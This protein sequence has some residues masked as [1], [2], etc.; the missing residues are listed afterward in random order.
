MIKS[1]FKKFI[2]SLIMLAVSVS[3]FI[4]S[5]GFSFNPRV[6]SRVII[7]G[8]EVGGLTY[9]EAKNKV[10][11]GIE[12][13]L[14]SKSLSVVGGSQTYTFRY[15]EIGYKDN[16]TE[17]MKDA[18]KGGKYR[19]QVSYYLC[20]LNTVASAICFNESV[21]VV[22]PYADFSRFGKPFTYHEG[23]DGKNVDVKQLKADICSS[24]NGDFGRVKLSFTKSYRTQTLD[25]VKSK[26]K[27]LASFTTYFDS[28]NLSRTSNIR[29]ASSF[30]NGAV[31]PAGKTIS[32]NDTV[33][34]RKKSRGFL[35]AKIIE[36]G[37]FTDGV[38]GGVCQ[39][40]TTLY[41]AALLSGLKIEEYHPHSLAVSYVPPSRDAMVSGT[42]CDLKI[43][44]TC[45]SPAYV[46]A[47]TG[48]NY[49]TFEIYGLKGE[50]EY[51]ISSEVTGEIKAEEELTNDP[52]KARDG[53][54][55]LTSAGYLTVIRDG[56]KKRVLLRKDKYLPVKGLKYVGDDIETAEEEAPN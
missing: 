13:E 42:T 16:L 9:A 19:V 26:T 37:E 40:S 56:Y 41:N 51:S 30:L 20:G 44:N 24:L 17:L 10:R 12:K 50:A 35:S 39:V 5:S 11:K 4:F 25:V 32:F 48:N 46:R 27:L 1:T 2:I 28:S 21:K 54:N 23:S 43:K 31:V 15:P 34:E 18:K 36:N 22:E 52:S 3:V 14:S 33:G 7:N 53:K 49:V 55:G 45:D 29:L 47:K 6:P 8:E 38:G